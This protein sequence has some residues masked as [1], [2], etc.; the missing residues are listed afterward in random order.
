M[1]LILL[2]RHFLMSFLVCF[3]VGLI[4]AQTNEIIHNTRRQAQQDLNNPPVQIN[5]ANNGRNNL[6]S[7]FIQFAN[8]FQGIP[9]QYFVSPSNSSTNDNNAQVISMGSAASF[10]DCDS[11]SGSHDENNQDHV[12]SFGGFLSPKNKCSGTS[13]L[14]S[15]KR[16][17]TMIIA[18]AIA[19]SLD[20]GGGDSPASGSKHQSTPEMTKVH[21]IPSLKRVRLVSDDAYPNLSTIVARPRSLTFKNSSYTVESSPKRRM[22]EMNNSTPTSWQNACR[23]ASHGYDATLPT[24]EEAALLFGFATKKL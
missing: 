8:S 13:E 11:S 20:Y 4:P 9:N 14:T 15:K 24:L 21:K 5:N 1:N 23:T 7:P 12:I 17:R 18:N 6:G 19:N 2:T 3:K 22:V 16:D 10:S